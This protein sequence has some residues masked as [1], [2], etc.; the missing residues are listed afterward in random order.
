MFH[1]HLIDCKVSRFPHTKTLTK[2]S[3]F[4]WVVAATEPGVTNGWNGL[5][6]PFVFVF[7]PLGARLN[8]SDAMIDSRVPILLVFSYRANIIQL[9]HCPIQIKLVFSF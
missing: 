9:Y 5:D 8:G 2:I 1:L 3:L 4:V 6:T 7:Y